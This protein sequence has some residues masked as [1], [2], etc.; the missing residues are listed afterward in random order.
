MHATGARAFSVLARASA[1]IL[2]KINAIRY[3]AV[4][5]QPFTLDFSEI[6]D[7]PVELNR[8]IE[9]IADVLY[10]IDPNDVCAGANAGDTDLAA[11]I[12]TRLHL[13]KIGGDAARILPVSWCATSLRGASGFAV[14]DDRMVPSGALD[15]A[16]MD[17]SGPTQLCLTT[18]QDIL[19]VLHMTHD[20]GQATLKFAL[21]AQFRHVKLC[22]NG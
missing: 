20:H 19:D 8:L 14:F 1:Q 15:S 5:D 17:I 12:A 18:W 4:S 22:G 2:L 16:I 21:A 6:H 7:H 10:S 11:R 9:M 13:P 3:D